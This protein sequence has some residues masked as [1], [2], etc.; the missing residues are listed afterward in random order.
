MTKVRENSVRAVYLFVVDIQSS[1]LGNTK[2][3]FLQ[4]KE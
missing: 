4:R 2:Y 3:Y 1:M